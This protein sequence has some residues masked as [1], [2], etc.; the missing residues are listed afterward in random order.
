MVNKKTNWV[1]PFVDNLNRNVMLEHIEEVES[2]L[3]PTDAD[4]NRFKKIEKHLQT[5]EGYKKLKS[6]RS[7]RIGCK[8][9]MG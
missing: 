7:D 9:M 5:L 4:Y 6:R 8:Q 2:G 1:Q 3:R